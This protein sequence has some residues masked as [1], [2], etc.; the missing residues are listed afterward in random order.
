MRIAFLAI[1]GIAALFAA[2]LP[3]Q[4]AST[5]S[6]PLGTFRLDFSNWGDGVWYYQ[7]LVFGQET[8]GVPGF[9]TQALPNGTPADVVV[10][11]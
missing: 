2:S 7:S 3:V 10:L 5:M 1:L 8:N 9:Q 4:A 11:P 6:L